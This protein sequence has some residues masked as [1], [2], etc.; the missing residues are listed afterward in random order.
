MTPELRMKYPTCSNC[1]ISP[2]GRLIAA[3]VDRGL[4]QFWSAPGFQP[5]GT[6]R[7]M[8]E[9]TEGIGRLFFS[10]NSRHLISVQWN[11]T[12]HIVRIPEAILAAQPASSTGSPTES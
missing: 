7:V 9:G 6:L 12:F 8:P 11:G 3:Q 10:A 1:R 5:C 4:I 2:D